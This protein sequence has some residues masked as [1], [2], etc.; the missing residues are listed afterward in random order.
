MELLIQN[1]QLTGKPKI[2][3]GAPFQAFWGYG[4]EYGQKI[5]SGAPVQALGGHSATSVKSSPDSKG[6]KIVQFAQT[7]D[8]C[9][10]PL[11]LNVLELRLQIQFA[12]LYLG[13]SGPSCAYLGFS[14]RSRN[15]KKLRVPLQNRS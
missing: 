15:T 13:L 3:S 14:G 10:M 1:A 7:S 8:L 4:R 9:K 11:H 12:Q 6:A 5:V 2:V